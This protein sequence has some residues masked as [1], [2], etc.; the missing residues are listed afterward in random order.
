[1]DGLA[2]KIGSDVDNSVH[3]PSQNRLPIVTYSLSFPTFGYQ[4]ILRE[5]S[6]NMCHPSG[7]SVPL[8]LYF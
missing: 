3:Y 7:T 2:I 4:S 8:M 6:R 5:R 1:M